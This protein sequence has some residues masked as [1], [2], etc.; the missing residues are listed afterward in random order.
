MI[1]EEITNL[2]EKIKIIN[3]SKDTEVTGIKWKL[4][5]KKLTEKTHWVSSILV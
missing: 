1:Q 2:L 4:Q 5:N 3:F